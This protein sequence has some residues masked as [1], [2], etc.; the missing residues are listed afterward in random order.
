MKPKIE[1]FMD[2]ADIGSGEKTPT[3][4]ADQKDTE[5]LREQQEQ[6][7]QQEHPMDGGSLLQVTEEQQFIAQRESHTPPEDADA[8]AA[9]ETLE[10]AQS[11]KAPG[12]EM[13][14][15][16]VA[17]HAASGATTKKSRRGHTRHET[18]RHGRAG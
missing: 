13:A 5:H 3:E 2:E 10:P 18:A 6:V 17:S 11:A 14:P 4:L 12:A 1:H 16:E 15:P 7:R 8:A 9:L